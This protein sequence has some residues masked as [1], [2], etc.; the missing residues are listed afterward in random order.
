MVNPIRIVQLGVDHPHGELY[1]TT[2]AHH[3]GFELVGGYDSDPVRAQRLLA[4]ESVDLPVFDSLDSALA[5]CQPKA[6]LVT[7]PNDVTPTAIVAAANRGLH[8]FAEKPCAVSAASFL[9]AAEAVHRTDVT[10]VAAYLRRFSPVANAMQSLAADGI[11]GDLLSAQIT[12]ATT[13]AQW[14]NAV[15]L[16]G[17]S[18]ERTAQDDSPSVR[19]DTDQQRHWLFDRTRSSGGIMHWLGV[20][21]LDLLR[22][23]IGEEFTQVSAILATRSSAPIDVEDVAAVSLESQ[24]GMIATVTC[25]Y[26]L[27]RGA[28][29]TRISIHGTSGWMQWDGSSSE[30]EVQSGHLAWK[31]E[32][33]RILRFTVDPKPGYAGALGWTAFDQFRAA[34]IDDGQ[35]PA[36]TDD[37]LRVLEILDA[38]QTSAR[39]HRR[40]R[41]ARTR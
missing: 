19:R 37:A 11:V 14:R 16:S 29:Q 30:I 25:G 3:D 10:F 35:L 20:H 33:Q 17:A 22:M 8:I 12:F 5:D 18:I 40:V 9:E 21:W 26:L 39:E 4:E 38:V 34:I 2:L 24:S 32:P 15:Y 6:T 7:L 28:D 13:N 1:R 23:V 31:A 41:I 36:T 27:E